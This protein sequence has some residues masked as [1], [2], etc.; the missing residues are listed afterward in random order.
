[1]DALG[2]ERNEGDERMLWLRR[3]GRSAAPGLRHG[4]ATAV[5]LVV[6]GGTTD[7]LMAT[8]RAQ[9]SAPAIRVTT[10]LVSLDVVVQDASGR[11]VTDLTAKDFLLKENGREQRIAAFTDVTG[12]AAVA[13]GGDGRTHYQFRNVPDE[14]RGGSVTLVLLDLVNTPTLE[15]AFARKELRR[16]FEGMPAGVRCGL[17]VLSGRL[18]VVQNVT[19][20]KED[21]I[22]AMDRLA[23]QPAELVRSE[24]DRQMAADSAVREQSAIGRSPAQGSNAPLREAVNSY[25]QRATT[26]Q[27]ALAQLTQASAGYP[28]RKNLIWIAGSFPVGIGPSLQTETTTASPR[29]LELAGLRDNTV[30]MAGSEIAIYPVS[31]RG[32]SLSAGGA[33]VS[34]EAEVDA[35]GRNAVRT[36]EG[37]AS[38]Q[39]DLQVSMEHLASLTGGRAFLNTNDLAGAMTHAAE[40]GGRYYRLDYSPENK[41]WDG[42]YRH[43]AV[44][45]RG[46]SYHLRYR[47][48]YF[49]TTEAQPEAAGSAGLS[50]ALRQETLERSG[51]LLQANVARAAT[52][53]G[54]TV[55]DLLIDPASMTFT[56]GQDGLRHAKL[57]LL[58]SAASTNGG[59]GAE[60]QAVLT[61]GLEPGD[62]QSVLAKGLPVRQTIARVPAGATLRVAVRDLQTGQTGTLRLQ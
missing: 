34:G 44:S 11:V 7:G 33:D 5:L 38:R 45:V 61:L 10:R 57:L 19:A 26:T 12:T 40:E 15:Q 16:F 28:G 54:E 1:M 25:E 41:K 48:G 47:Q 30:A 46:Q 58:L 35:S 21:L 17:F 13:S 24:S 18:R 36:I 3:T 56:T 42:A 50:T 32:M 23:V 37:Q 51:I 55:V 29:L 43:L 20:K 60:K 52:P 53:T 59:P 39:F 27:E 9:T 31:T 62:Y 2:R 49:A 6:V 22:A 14:A 4:L 8:G